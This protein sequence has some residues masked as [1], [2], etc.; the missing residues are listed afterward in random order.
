L[1]VLSRV[2]FIAALLSPFVAFGQSATALPKGAAALVNGVPISESALQVVVN[3]AVARGLQS[4]SALRN[5]YLDGLIRTQLLAQRAQ[6]LGL[7]AHVTGAM[8]L[9]Q[10]RVWAESLRQHQ[11]QSGGITD[12]ELQKE[13]NERVNGINIEQVAL[14]HIVVPSKDAANTLLAQLKAGT[15]FRQLALNHSIDTH[16]RSAG[17]DLGWRYPR[18]LHPAVAEAVAKMQKGS[19]LGEPVQTDIGWH[20]LQLN[21]KRPSPD[22]TD[23]DSAQATLAH[24]KWIDFTQDVLSGSANI[25]LTPQQ[26]VNPKLLSAATAQAIEAGATDSP[27]LR[28]LVRREIA[29]LESLAQA[30]K[31]ETN[32]N[33][34]DLEARLRIA[35]SSV[36]AAA[37]QAFWIERNE[38]TEA[39]I[40]GVFTTQQAKHSTSTKRIEYRVSEIVL[41]TKKAAQDVLAKLNAGASFSA[42]AAANMGGAGTEASLD[43]GDWQLATDMVPEIGGAIVTLNKGD[44]AAN[45]VQT[46]RGWHV[47]KVMDARAQAGPKSQ[48]DRT[49]LYQAVQ[50]AKWRDYLAQLRQRATIVQ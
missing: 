26:A 38:P 27:E 33:A 21:N 37:L 30:A 5:A 43:V 8:A 41:P 29:L 16:S 34:K 32:I 4:T 28:A 47:V 23:K 15:S 35:E 46:P 48:S 36:L 24:L 6:Q 17:G 19:I 45:P 2:L 31:A 14:S 13:I 44:I 39:E 18:H 7:S 42:L 25:S 49:E 1:P 9:A 22:A 50:A 11:R 12:A 20:V 3:D 10:E 40:Q